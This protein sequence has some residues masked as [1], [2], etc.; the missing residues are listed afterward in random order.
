MF[1]AVVTGNIISE[2]IMETIEFEHPLARSILTKLRDRETKPDDFH[3][4]SIRLGHLLAVEATRNLATVPLRVDTPLEST[5]GEMC[6]E[7]PV[8]LPILRAGLG[9]LAPFQDLLPESPVAFVG[10]RRDEETGDPEWLYDSLPKV[11]GRHVMILDPMLATAGTAKSVVDQLIE[12]GVDE[13]TL[14]S[15]VA[16]PE[17]IYRLSE[18]ENLRLITV[19][20]DREL[21][22]NWYILPGLGDFGDRLF[23]EDPTTGNG[24]E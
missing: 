16:A 5:L 10:I 20:V 19:S 1:H 18:Y 11:E 8:L 4:L 2:R 21:D 12:L 3:R 14:V 22:E 23:G 7:V 24:Q 17:G 15:V 6:S 9:M 13:I